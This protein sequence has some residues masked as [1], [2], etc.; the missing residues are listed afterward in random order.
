[1]GESKTYSQTSK[2]SERTPR[3]PGRPPQRKGGR[4]KWS[5][6]HGARMLNLAIK[7]A[8]AKVGQSG[9]S[10]TQNSTK[11]GEKKTWSREAMIEQQQLTESD[12]KCKSKCPWKTRVRAGRDKKGKGQLRRQT[13]E[14]GRNIQ[15]DH[16]SNDR[17]G[18]KDIRNDLN[19][20]GLGLQNGQKVSSKST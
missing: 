17:A 18:K 3:R 11:G 5:R 12:S 15:Q 20:K 19:L 2:Q 7:R 13:T 9:G 14:G 6:N 4:D 1:M 8:A 16:A 10:V